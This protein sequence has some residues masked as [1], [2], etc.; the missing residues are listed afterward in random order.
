MGGSTVFHFQNLS[1]FDL[2]VPTLFVLSTDI[3][4]CFSTECAAFSFSHYVVD[5]TQ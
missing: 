2:L 1:I 5:I 3:N 4:A